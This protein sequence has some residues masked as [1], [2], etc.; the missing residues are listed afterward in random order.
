V[1][2]C[3]C[4]RVCACVCVCVCLR[5]RVYVRARVYECARACECECVSHVCVY[6]S[7]LR[8]RCRDRRCQNRSYCRARLAVEAAELACP[9]FRP[10]RSKHSRRYCYYYYYSYYYYYYY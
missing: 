8:V 9:R 6:V 4:V 1:Y 3:V 2:V 7:N 5:S 10:R